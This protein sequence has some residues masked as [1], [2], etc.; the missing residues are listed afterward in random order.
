MTTTT[1]KRFIRRCFSLFTARSADEDLAR[2]MTSHLSILEEEHCR[3]GLT[4]DEAR[5]AARRAMGS[6]ALAKDLPPRCAIVRMDRRC[7][8]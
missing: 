8:A 4:P 2:E 7:A 3:R 1:M 6:V 5:L